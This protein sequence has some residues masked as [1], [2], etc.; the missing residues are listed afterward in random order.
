MLLKL[1]TGNKAQTIIRLRTGFL[2]RCQNTIWMGYSIGRAEESIKPQPIIRLRAKDFC[3]PL[4]ILII[5]P[6]IFL[7]IDIDGSVSLFKYMYINVNNCIYLFL[8][9]KR[10]ELLDMCAIEIEDIIIII[11]IYGMQLSYSLKF[12]SVVGKTCGRSRGTSIITIS[13]ITRSYYRKQNAADMYMQDVLQPKSVFF[14]VC[15]I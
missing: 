4:I 11:I 2:W 14:T 1:V 12:V 9:V 8:F 7:L 15:M 5:V 3:M 13:I 10:L 6:C